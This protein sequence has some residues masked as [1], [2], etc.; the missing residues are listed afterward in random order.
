MKNDLICDA[1][2]RLLSSFLHLTLSLNLDRCLFDAS[3]RLSL[4][5]SFCWGEV[6]DFPTAGYQRLGPV[7]IRWKLIKVTRKPQS[8]SP[9]RFQR[10][11]AGW[12]VV[13]KRKGSV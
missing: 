11:I 2:L 13:W 10:D 9:D 12:K 8:L 5:S 6:V 3:D 7:D 4:T 1:K